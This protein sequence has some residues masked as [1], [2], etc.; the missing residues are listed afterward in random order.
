MTKKYHPSYRR[1]VDARKYQTQLI[2]LCSS[3]TATRIAQL[4]AQPLSQKLAYFD[5]SHASACQVCMSFHINK[6]VES[7][8]KLFLIFLSY[9]IDEP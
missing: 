3:G 8:V 9:Y 5:G 1:Y 7:L 4:K 2:Q 6:D